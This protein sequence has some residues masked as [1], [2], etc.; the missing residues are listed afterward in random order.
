MHLRVKR[1]KYL[2]I[3][4]DGYL[5]QEVFGTVA[6][7]CVKLCLGIFSFSLFSLIYFFI[8]ILFIF[9][10]FFLFICNYVFFLC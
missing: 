10:S 3:N 4:L 6:E 1:T 9:F 5:T 2:P 8:T 7:N